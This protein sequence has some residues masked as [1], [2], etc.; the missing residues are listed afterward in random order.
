MVMVLATILIGRQ[1]MPQ[2]QQIRWHGVGDNADAFPTDAE[3]VDTDGDGVGDN[4]VGRQM[5]P[6]SADSDGDGV[7]DNA[8]AFPTVPGNG[9]YRW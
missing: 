9:R 4:S 7:G 5:M 1:M 3:T 6:R 8:G 2:N